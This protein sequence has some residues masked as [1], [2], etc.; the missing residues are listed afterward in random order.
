MKGGMLRAL[1]NPARAL[2]IAFPL[3]MSI[4]LAAAAMLAAPQAQAQPTTPGSPML[5]VTPG[6]ESTSLGLSWTASTDADGVTGYGV[7]LRELPAAFPSVTLNFANINADL[8]DWPS[9]SSASNSADLI[10]FGDRL[11]DAAV[12]MLVFSNLK[13]GTMYQAR[14]VTQNVNGQYSAGWAESAVVTTAIDAHLNAITL[15]PSAGASELQPAFS[16]VILTYRASVVQ[17]A[18]NLTL[19]ATFSGDASAGLRGATAM[20]LTSGSA[21]GEIAL[22]AG[23]NTIEIIAGPSDDQITYVV[24]VTRANSAPL[25]PRAP[26]LLAPLGGELTLTWRMPAGDGGA[27]ITQYRVRWA[28]SEAPGVY[29]GDGENGSIVPGGAGARTYT[30]TGLRKLTQYDAQVAAENNIGIGLWG[31]ARGMLNSSP[32]APQNVR[33]GSVDGALDLSWAAPANNGG[34]AISGYRVRW[35]AGADSTTWINPARADGEGVSGGASTLT[36][37]VRGL[38]NGSTYAVQVA[39]LNAA[40]TGDWSESPGAVPAGPPAAPGDLL[41]RE[42]AGRLMLTWSAPVDDGG[43]AISGY[44]VRWAEGADSTTWV[45]PPGAVGEILATTATEYTLPNNNINIGSLYEIQVAARNHGGSGAFSASVRGVVAA[46]VSMP[47]TAKVTENIRATLRIIMTPGQSTRA[48]DRNINLVHTDVSATGGQRS[49]EG[50]YISL[51]DVF[52]FPG[53]DDFVNYPVNTNDDELVEADEVFHMTISKNNAEDAS[54]VIG[55]PTTVV[56]IIDDDRDSAAIAFG[57]DTAATAAYTASASE[58]DG[59]LNVPVRI[60]HA[61]STDITFLIRAVTT[62]G[63]A[64]EGRDYRL[65]SKRVMFPAGADEAARTQNIV[66]TLIDDTLA[67]VDEDIVLR[68]VPADRVVNDLGDYYARTAAATARISLSSD[69]TPPPPVFTL[70]PGDGMLTLNWTPAGG[71]ISGYRARW[72]LA[73]A[74]NGAP[75]AWNDDDGIDAGVD[76]AHTI[77]GLVNGSE[78]EVQMAAVNA[79][80]AGAFSA[81]LRDAPTLPPGVPNGL[82]AETGAGRLILTWTAPTEIDREAVTG[83]AVRWAEG[84][85]STDWITPPGEDSLATGSAEATYVL[86]GLKSATTYEVQIA[87]GNAAGFGAW[88]QSAQGETA[89]FDLDVDESGGAPDWRDGVMVARYLAGLRGAPLTA[90]VGGASPANVA[91]KINSGVLSGALDIDG[92]NATTAADGIMVAR[93]L[94]GVTEGAAL[95]D[96]QTDAANEAAVKTKM[97]ELLPQ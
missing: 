96:G 61:P 45:N 91:A 35:A 6:A 50:D 14:V 87:A 85:A 47:A 27:D 48:P 32:G 28:E 15:A 8:T 80:G 71:S 19:T 97:M 11:F 30:L 22:S 23:E 68:I 92:A 5:T 66:I 17:D 58:A 67:E 24:I 18:A 10:G 39:A 55:A 74:G 4:A 82:A 21:S 20:T 41:A 60:S 53:G 79:A 29:L 90:G 36:Y 3:A 26:G 44:A 88:T 93:Y 40:G 77:T 9:Y 89:A 33:I 1:R 59:T 83:Y 7:Q 56:T 13:P 52:L 63:G 65:A 46:T 31:G 16:R 76:G 62:A 84:A 43:D 64:I 57:T 42:V 78:Y 70:Q 49:S 51:P 75:G 95:T 38:S 12:T 94:L 86:R 69:E 54:Y 25:T 34:S 81:S 72:R 2:S 37:T 73:D